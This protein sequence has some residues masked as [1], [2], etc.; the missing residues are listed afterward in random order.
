MQINITIKTVKFYIIDM[1]TEIY[2][3]CDTLTDYLR[4]SVI[5]RYTK[6]GDVDN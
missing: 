6:M 1:Y 5:Q 3:I 4:I 2:L